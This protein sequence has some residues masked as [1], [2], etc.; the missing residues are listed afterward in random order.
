MVIFRSQDPP[1]G[2][3][4]GSLAQRTLSF[5]KLR[6]I[7]PLSAARLSAGS[8]FL[9]RSRDREAVTGLSWCGSLRARPSKAQIWGRPSRAGNGVCR[10]RGGSRSLWRT[11]PREPG[12]AWAAPRRP[13]RQRRLE[14]AALRVSGRG[15][16][17][18]L[19][20]LG[21]PVSRSPGLQCEQLAE[22]LGGQMK[23]K[24]CLPT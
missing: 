6:V 23:R 3:L 17:G 15:G 10:G 13:R 2:S 7:L 5:L 8:P 14:P 22:P 11:G 24:Q 16:A 20:S 4:S 12:N 9:S 19:G 18:G 21:R 1:P